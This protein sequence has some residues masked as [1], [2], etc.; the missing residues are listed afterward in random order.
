L[1]KIECFEDEVK[2]KIF[3]IK[4]QDNY[5]IADKYSTWGKADPEEFFAT[6]LSIGWLWSIDYTNANE[7]EKNDWVN[8]EI[9]A[10]IK[11]ALVNGKS[12][13]ILGNIYSLESNIGCKE[14]IKNVKKDINFSE[15]KFK[16]DLYSEGLFFIPIVDGDVADFSEED[17]YNF[18]GLES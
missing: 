9:N 5:F 18:S 13:Y 16:M 11:W 3:D 2:E 15:Q 17:I 7:Q 1:I 6:F 12:I 4:I 10:M 8:G 14:I